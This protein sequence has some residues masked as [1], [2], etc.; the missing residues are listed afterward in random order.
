VCEIDW[1]LLPNVIGAIANLVM[2]L[3]AIV[4]AW[5]ALKQ[6]RES[7]HNKLTQIALTINADIQNY[8]NSANIREV[9]AEILKLLKNNPNDTLR[10]E[11]L[12]QSPNILEIQAFL[13]RMNN[14]C[15]MIGRLPSDGRDT[16]RGDILRTIDKNLVAE[17]KCLAPLINK[18][19]DERR[20][21]GL[22]NGS[23]YMKDFEDIVTYVRE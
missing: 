10:L 6:L 9:R 13:A 21:E 12:S 17:W 7:E 19:R 8:R 5:F 18:R 22:D 23:W 1:N 16:I 11:K 20:Q 14:L 2:A 4:A 15:W 3:V